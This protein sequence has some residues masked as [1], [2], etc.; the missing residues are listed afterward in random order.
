[1]SFPAFKV[2]FPCMQSY[3]YT[4]W[5]PPLVLKSK[6]HHDQYPGTSQRFHTNILLLG[7]IFTAFL[8]ALFSL[9]WFLCPSSVAV[10]VFQQVFPQPFSFLPVNSGLRAFTT[11]VVGKVLYTK[12]YYIYTEEFLSH[13]TH[14]HLHTAHKT[15]LF[16]RN[17]F[18]DGRVWGGC[19]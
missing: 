14:W 17:A 1:M 18:P 9:A 8:P 10:L 19:P 7:C 16:L 3:F 12:K 5:F 11:S 6:F 2:D 15:R 4:S 13:P